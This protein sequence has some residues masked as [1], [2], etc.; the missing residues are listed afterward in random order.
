MDLMQK[1]QEYEG[2]LDK[3]VPEFRKRGITKAEAERDYRVA[4]AKKFLELK[5]QGEKVTIMSDLA[6]GD[7][8]VAQLKC[9]YII[10]ETLY[11]SAKEA[12]MVYK[13]QIDT[14]MVV[15]KAEWGQAK[16]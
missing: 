15:F 11:D 5:A 4:L 13:K 8:A 10:A 2:L 1:V 6:R 16:K 7:E 14:L 3:A 12:I 9:D